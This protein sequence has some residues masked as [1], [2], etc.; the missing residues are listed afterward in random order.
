M[1]KS[2]VR[3]GFEKDNAVPH[4]VVNFDFDLHNGNGFKFPAWV[5]ADTFPPKECLPPDTD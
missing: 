5:T 3:I 2:C 4:L 1:L